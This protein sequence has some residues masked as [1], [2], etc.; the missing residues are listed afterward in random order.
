MRRSRNR[1]RCRR[2][3]RCHRQGMGIP[4]QLEPFGTLQRG[5]S[6]WGRRRPREAGRCP[7]RPRVTERQG[8]PP[9]AEELRTV[10]VAEPTD[11]ETEMEVVAMRR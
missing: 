9:L 11:R 10:E 1:R 7:R 4:C 5:C 6:L 2:C 3:R 8:A